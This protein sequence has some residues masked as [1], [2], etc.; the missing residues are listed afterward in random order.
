MFSCAVRAMRVIFVQGSASR[1]MPAM[2]GAQ[3][4]DIMAAS[5]SAGL[6]GWSTLRAL[7]LFVGHSGGMLGIGW[8]C[9]HGSRPADTHVHHPCKPDD[10]NEAC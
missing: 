7:S 6:L 5:R 10:D 8:I 2:R 1:A 3:R 9:W 4:V